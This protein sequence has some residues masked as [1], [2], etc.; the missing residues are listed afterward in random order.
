VTERRTPVNEEMGFNS[1]GEWTIFADVSLSYAIDPQK[2][3]EFYIK[4]RVSDL[5]LFTAR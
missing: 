5:E 3:P 1:K 2:V 4:Y